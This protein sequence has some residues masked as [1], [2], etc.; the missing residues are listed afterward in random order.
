M[1]TASH[2]SFLEDFDKK[3]GSPPPLLNY[4]SMENCNMP[5]LLKELDTEMGIMPSTLKDSNSKAGLLCSRQ[6]VVRRLA[7]TN[8]A[9][10][11]DCRTTSEVCLCRTAT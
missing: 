2:L 7:K 11:R 3:I 1:E 4:S 8:Q 10:M 9:H 6:K 5:P